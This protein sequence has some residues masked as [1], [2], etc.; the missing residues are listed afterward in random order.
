MVETP[1]AYGRGSHGNP[2]AGKDPYQADA[3]PS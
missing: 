1:V 3:Y 2:G